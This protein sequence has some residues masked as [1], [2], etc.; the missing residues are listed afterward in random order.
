TISCQ[1][2]DWSTQFTIYFWNVNT[3]QPYNITLNPGASSNLQ[4]AAG[5][6]NVSFYQTGSNTNCFIAGTFTA[7]NEVMP[8]FSNVNFFSNDNAWIGY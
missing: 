3:G 7:C 5:T 1:N 2:H 6:Y 4:I 8:S